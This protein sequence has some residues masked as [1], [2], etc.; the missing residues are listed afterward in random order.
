LSTR[1]R[2]EFELVGT[3][4]NIE[5]ILNRVTAGINRVGSSGRSTNKELGLIDKQLMAIGTTARYA[6]AGS[7][8]FGITS[9]IGKLTDFQNKLAQVAALAGRVTGGT[10]T[11]PS[12]NL[13]GDIGSQAIIESNKLGI[14]VSDIEDYMTRF[15]S[16]FAD[17]ARGKQGLTQL[18][19]FS[20]EVARLQA[21]LGTEAGD[22][23]MLA[24]G[25][26]GL[27]NQMPGGTR[28]IGRSTNKVSNLI[29]ELLSRTPNITG[30]DVARDIGRVGATMQIANMTPEQAF[31]VWT[32]AGMAGGSSSVIGRGVAQ[33]LGTSLLHPN[34]PDQLK[35][36]Q[37]IG[38]STDPTT[39][40]NMGGWRVL[41]QMMQA[42]APHGARIRNKAALGNEDIADE[43]AVNAA[44]VSGVNLTLLYNLLGR[45]ESVRQFV[46]IL[47]AGGE[48][49]LVGQLKHNNDAIKHNTAAQREA[50]AMGQR[51]LQTLGNSLGNIPLSIVRGPLNAASRPLAYGASHVSNLLAEHRTTTT[52]IEGLM[53]TAL[54]VA[55]ASKLIR[56]FRQARGGRASAAA[57]G[58][59]I[60]AEE[61][62]ALI[63]GQ[64]PDGSRGN[65]FWVMIAPASWLV[66]SPGGF[67]SGTGNG[68]PPPRGGNWLTKLKSLGGYGAAAWS[69]IGWLGAG[70]A[71][72]AAS[73]PP[74]FEF[75]ANRFTG[76]SRG[77][78]AGHPLLEHFAR[79]GGAM[80]GTTAPGQMPSGA[81]QSIL[82]EFA[83]GMIGAARAEALL[84]LLDRKQGQGVSGAVFGRADGSMDVTVRLVDSQGRTIATQKKG[85]V[86]VKW[87]PQT[88][89]P[90]SSGKPGTKKGSH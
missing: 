45:Q 53:G 56:G 88:G 55:G 8:V 64:T 36:F 33:L 74:A 42:V 12:G 28:N 44:G 39:L 11:A 68:P 23:Q 51:S 54:G 81:Q 22:P 16:S 57:L 70:T 25:I 63:A 73:I 87:W 2:V 32:Q 41:Q 66:G 35:A 1:R 43:D 76:S 14:A 24:G 69:R 65:P 30:R 20:D 27:V 38:L 37:S 4:S 83:S 52:V 34:T 80:G 6:L 21:A 77:V 7:F 79:M 13:L 31:A 82:N 47:G 15:Y 26:A 86:P 40:R 58:S 72:A 89:A 17:Q 48:Q 18:R 10:Y 90:T 59:A 78:P 71:A 29:W 46:N 85:G 49:G 61:L 84:S 50:A 3:G 62:P 19:V 75:I 9:A 67:S 60:T 5:A